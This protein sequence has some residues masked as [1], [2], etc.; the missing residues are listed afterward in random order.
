MSETIWLEKAYA[1]KRN[2]CNV[3]NEKRLKKFE[4]KMRCFK[5]FINSLSV[6]A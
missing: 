1:Q 6:L 3:E 5:S 4:I 2:R